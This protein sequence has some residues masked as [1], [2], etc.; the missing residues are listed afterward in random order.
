MVSAA[1]HYDN[2]YHKNE[3][4]PAEFFGLLSK[5]FGGI[6]C[7]GQENRTF[8]GLKANELF[9]DIFK[10]SPGSKPGSGESLKRALWKIISAVY[11]RFKAPNTEARKNDTPHMGITD[12]A[13][14]EDFL[15]DGF[16]IITFRD[17][18]YV[19]PTYLI[20]ICEKPK[21]DASC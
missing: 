15:F 3:F 1:Y 9:R 12:N 6:H 10:P 7:F 19:T 2:P 8:L 16:K 17:N 11:Y 18:L 13:D 5:Y 4:Y 14:F 21:K 20:A